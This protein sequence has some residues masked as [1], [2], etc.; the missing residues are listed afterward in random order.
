MKNLNE[1]TKGLLLGHGWNKGKKLPSPS[2]ST[3][4][5]MSEAQ[6]GSKGNNWKGGIAPLNQIIRRS[7]EY[8]LWR[9]AVFTRDSYTC[10]FCG[11]KNGN[12]KT[13][14]LEADHIKSFSLFPE[15]RFA[16]DN[17]RTLCKDCHKKTSTYG[18]R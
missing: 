11:A 6:C 8:R 5:K 12:G 16:L 10:R 18:S 4:K 1:K 2:V 7:L 9:T 3:R 17:G 14:R 15:L 13:I